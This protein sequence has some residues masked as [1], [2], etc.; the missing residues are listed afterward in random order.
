MDASQK[1]KKQ[2]NY[3]QTACISVLCDGYVKKALSDMVAIVNFYENQ[4]WGRRE[5]TIVFITLC[6]MNAYGGGWFFV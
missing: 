1:G 2:K 4:Y 3:H 5:T 6:L